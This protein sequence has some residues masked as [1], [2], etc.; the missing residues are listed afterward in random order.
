MECI[1]RQSLILCTMK[2]ATASAPAVKR[3]IAKC[4][5]RFCQDTLP[6]LLYLVRCPA[7]SKPNQPRKDHVMRPGTW[8]ALCRTLYRLV[9]TVCLVLTSLGCTR[10]AEKFCGVDQ[11]TLKQNLIRLVQSPVINDT[12]GLMPRLSQVIA[13]NY[14]LP[15]TARPRFRSSFAGPPVLATLV[16]IIP[17]TGK[18]TCKRRKMDIVT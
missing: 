16:P 1:H 7:V 9:I 2:S 11:E 12:I 14:C 6:W 10:T 13:S 18:P 15:A 4:V 3:P 5:Q 8:G 17:E